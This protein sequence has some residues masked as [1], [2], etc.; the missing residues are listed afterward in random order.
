MNTRLGFW[1]ICCSVVV[2][3]LLLIFAAANAD[4]LTFTS[5]KVLAEPLEFEKESL[6]LDAKRTEEHKVL[7]RAVSAEAV[8]SSARLITGGTYELIQLLDSAGIP[9]AEVVVNK[10]FPTVVYFNAEALCS[11][12]PKKPIVKDAE[13]KK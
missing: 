2:S 12:V 6:L 11:E 4:V 3:A 1:F 5:T 7:I 13:L 9:R 10:K 8:K